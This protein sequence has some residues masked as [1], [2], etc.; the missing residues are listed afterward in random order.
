MVKDLEGL[1]L[2]GH[3]SGEG[4]GRIAWWIMED[5]G[6]QAIFDTG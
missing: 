4:F 1:R 6:D 5:R 3:R 2:L